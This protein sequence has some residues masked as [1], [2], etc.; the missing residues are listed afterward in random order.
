[1]KSVLFLFLSCAVLVV[2]MLLLSGQMNKASYLRNFFFFPKRYQEQNTK[3]HYKQEQERSNLEKN[4]YANNKL[5]SF[6]K[7]RKRILWAFIAVVLVSIYALLSVYFA[8]FLGISLS[9]K[10]II[11]IQSFAVVFVFLAL[12]SQLGWEI[13][14]IDGITLN[15]YINDLWFKLLN[16]ISIYLLLFSN[17]YQLVI[18]NKI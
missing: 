9:G 2:L 3:E 18:K 14:T 17:I 6:H 15:E 7:L 11:L 5:Q 12:L 8:S 4:K 13:Q 1:M 16:V 10:S